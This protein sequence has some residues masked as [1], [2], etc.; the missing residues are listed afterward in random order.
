MENPIVAVMIQD[1][2]E[3]LNHM[4][5]VLSDLG[6]ETH[7]ANGF[8]EASRLVKRHRPHLVFVNQSQWSDSFE[9]IVE[10][11]NTAEY[12]LDI[13]VVG[14]IPQVDWRASAIAH[15]AFN[16]VAPPFSHEKLAREVHLA[17]IDVMDRREALPWALHP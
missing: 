6:I 5:G 15:G 9:E 2:Y 12:L 14:P 17:Y 4:A 8:K 11:A 1:E 7:Y 10:L 16:Y 3:S 13:L